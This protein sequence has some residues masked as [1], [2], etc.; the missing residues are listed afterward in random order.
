VRRS[1]AAVLAAGVLALA[2]LV[3]ASTAWAHAT[4]VKAEPADGGVIGQAPA[5][6][7]L[8]FNE[9][10][11]P[12]A[13]RLIGPGGDAVALGEIVAADA[14]LTVAVPPLPAG[15]HVLSWRVISADGH[16]V[17]GSLIF[18]IG[19]PSAQPPAVASPSTDPAVRAAVWAARLAI[20][21]GLFGGIGGAF[22]QA[23]VASPR[24]PAAGPLVVAALVTGLIGTPLSVGLQ[25]L[26]A[27]ELPLREIMH[28]AVWK[29][30]L[31]TAYGLTAIVAAFALFAA[32][33]SF[34]TQSSRI[35]RALSLIGLIGVGLAL[36]LSGHASNAAPR[37]VS[38][39]TVFLHGICVAFWVGS[40]L[41]LLATLRA[42][43]PNVSLARFSRAIPIPLVL[44]AVSGLWL[45]WV[46]LGRVDALWTTDYG[47]VLSGKLIAVAILL[48]LAAVN[49]Y[50]LVPRYAA[51][52]TEAARP[53][54]LSIAF[55]FALVLAILALVA[56][57]RFTPP[58]RSLAAA[59]TVS[60]HIHG[61]K[62][63]AQIEIER[64]GPRASASVTVLDG[65]FRPLPAKEVTLVLA[66]PAA[67][68]EPIRRAAAHG[69]NG[70]WRVDDLR[71]P[72]A[73]RWNLRVEILISDFDKAM[74]DETVVLPRMP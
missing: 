19:A 70:T 35:A 53:L 62:A 11:S 46:Q 33:F 8:T 18:S 69:T 61:E 49:R 31:E 72:V 23:W 24:S 26:D 14:S 39:P 22:F 16:P 28:A 34:A 45:A 52:G 15:T 57:W 63:M 30:G 4:L 74:L 9:P 3:P 17:G 6:L 2:L 27:L 12:L 13:I 21:L 71:I 38:R 65:G 55:E 47:L 43:Q 25:G 10:V 59:T 42:P 40:L 51:R 50:R 54:R 67:G 66:N 41:P 44:I 5:V 32:L 48:G 58:P 36:A 1:I 64:A 20:Y 37:A 7:R 60:V 56:L 68:I 29:A 73:G